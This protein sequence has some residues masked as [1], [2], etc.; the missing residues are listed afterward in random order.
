MEQGVTHWTNEKGTYMKFRL[1]K[2]HYDMEAGSEWFDAGPVMSPDGLGESRVVIA[3]EG[4]TSE[5]A[6]R[7]VPVDKLEKIDA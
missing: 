1:I 6:L 3:V 4:D 2:H 7:I 5:G